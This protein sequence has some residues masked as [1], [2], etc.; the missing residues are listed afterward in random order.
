MPD[1]LLQKAGSL[2]SQECAL[3]R[4]YTV[5]G[6]QILEGSLLLADLAP[7]ARHHHEHWDGSGFPDHLNR[8]DIPL[9]ARIIAVAETYDSLQRGHVPQA[10]RSSEFALTD[11]QC[12]AGSQFDPTVV[13]IL[14]EILSGQQEQQI[15]QEESVTK[16]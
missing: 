11:L 13:Q 3:L 15:L 4:E 12:R 8:A 7:A 9:A 2:T 6:A 10:D 16:G 1:K 14:T 5:L